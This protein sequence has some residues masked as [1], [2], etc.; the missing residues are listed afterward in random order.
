MTDSA[1]LT[2]A[3]VR[4]DEANSADPNTEVHEGVVQPK[5][6]IY[7][8]RM[9]AWL[10]RLAPDASETLQLAVRCQH[11]RR[12]EIPRGDY[13][14]DRPG[15]YAWRTA[16]AR[17]HGDKA[18]EILRETGYS[19]DEISTVRTLLLKKQ[20]KTN[21]DAQTLEDAAAL[22]FLDNHLSDFAARDDMDE[23]KLVNILRK[24]W[25][26]MSPNGHEAAKTLDLS[27]KEAELI[28]K[29]LAPDS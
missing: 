16:L 14:M 21:S 2:E 23:E 6:L 12:W 18:A 15:Y 26:K 10:Q 24:T 9:T 13:P 8:K 19:D 25:A 3:F 5:E 1:R 7:S 28:A 29:A 17:Y 4:I 11:L 27:S 22:V 20:I